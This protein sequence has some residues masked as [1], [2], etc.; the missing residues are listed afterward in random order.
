MKSIGILDPQEEIW[1]NQSGESY[2]FSEVQNF[3]DTIAPYN[4]ICD[5]SQ[6]FSGTL[7]RFPLRTKNSKLSNNCHTIS[8]L[9]KLF[10]AFIK[11]AHCL[12]LFLKSVV[13]VQ[14]IELPEISNVQFHVTVL[15]NDV[16]EYQT[17]ITGVSRMLDSQ[18]M[19][20]QPLVKKI[21]R[22][23]CVKVKTLDC[24]FESKWLVVEQV[25]SDNCEVLKVANQLHLLPWVGVAYEVG[26][27]ELRLGGRVFCCLPMPDEISSPL[28]VHVNGTFGLSDDRR[29]LK[30]KTTER[31]NDAVSIWNEMIV[32]KLLPSCYAY[33]IH[34]CTKRCHLFAGD[35]YSAWPDVIEVEKDSNWGS[36]LEPFFNCLVKLNVLWTDDVLCVGSL[37]L[38]AHVAE[39]VIVPSDADISVLTAIK[40]VMFKCG[41]KLV[42]VPNNVLMGLKYS[43]C[44]LTWLSPDLVRETLKTNPQHYIDVCKQEKLIILSYCLSDRAYS[45]IVGMVLLPLLNGTFETFETLSSTRKVFLCTAD[46]PS[47]LF[48]SF[49]IVHHLLIDEAYETELYDVAKSGATQLIMLDDNQAAAI[50]HTCLPTSCDIYLPEKCLPTGWLNLF[51]KWS[52]SHNLDAF[53][54]LFVVPLS[55]PLGCI[56]RLI[57]VKDSTVMFVDDDDDDD[58][59]KL[60]ECIKKLHLSV[61]ISKDYPYLCRKNIFCFMHKLSANG[62]LTALQNI[63]R[64]VL[65]CTQLSNNDAFAI[66][67]LLARMNKIT[68]SQLE[69]VVKIP[70]LITSKPLAI[71]VQSVKQDFWRSQVIVLPDDLPF[72][73]FPSRM[74]GVSKTHNQ[75]QFLQL[76]R[77]LGYVQFPTASELIMHTLLPMIADKTASND[78]SMAVMEE[79]LTFLTDIDMYSNKISKLPFIKVDTTSVMKSPSELYNP[80]EELCKLFYNQPVFP[81]FPFNHPAYVTKL[82]RC[83]L[84]CNIPAIEILN[85]IKD[86]SKPKGIFPQHVDEI[87]MTRSCAVLTH[88]SDNARDFQQVFNSLAIASS[89]FPI[90]CAAPEGYPKCLRW[91]GSHSHSHFISYCESVVLV[92]SD[93]IPYIAGSQVYMVR[94][95]CTF[96]PAKLK[97]LSCTSMCRP[98]HVLAHFKDV[99]DN[100]KQI[101]QDTLLTIIHHTYTFLTEHYLECYDLHT[102]SHPWIWTGD[103]FVHPKVVAMKKKLRFQHSFEPYHYIIPTE[104]H[105]YDQL[106]TYFG[107]QSETTDL[108]LV[109]TIAAIKHKCELDEADALEMIICIL[110]QLTVFGQ[111]K[112][113][114]PGVIIY[115]PTQSESL[116]LVNSNEVVYSDNECLKRYIAQS[117]LDKKYNVIHNRISSLAK[118]LHVAPLSNSISKNEYTFRNISQHEPLTRR[119]NNILRDYKDGLTIIK[120]LIQNADDA[121]ATEMNICF[122]ARTH[123]IDSKMLLFPGMASSHGPALVVYNNAQFTEADFENITE[124]AGAT[125]MDEP[126]KI[127]KFGLGFCSVYHITDIP[128]FI[129]GDSFAVF[130][131]TGKHLSEAESDQP[132]GHRI[133]LAHPILNSSQQLH[134]YRGLY[135]FDYQEKYSGT[136]FRFPFRVVAS[137]ISDNIYTEAGVKILQ[138]DIFNAGSKLLIFLKNVAKITF[139]VF[140]KETKTPSTILELHKADGFKVCDGCYHCMVTKVR[141][142]KTAYDHWLVSKCDD[143][144]AYQGVQKYALASVACLLQCE[145]HEKFLLKSLEG[146][147]FCY[148][149][150]S[151]QTG[152][153]V[154]ISSNFAVIGNRRGVWTADCTVSHRGESESE[155]NIKLMQTVIPQAYVCLLNALKVLFEDGILMD[156]SFY[157]VWPLAI[158]LKQHDPWTHFIHRVYQIITSCELLYSVFATKWLS[159]QSCQFIT[160]AIL[161]LS[162]EC[163]SCAPEVDAVLK[164]LKLL[165]V[166]LPQEYQNEI[167]KSSTC[168][169]DMFTERCFIDQFYCNVNSISVSSRVAVLKKMFQVYFHS[170]YDKGRL[171]DLK[172][173][174]VSKPSVPCIPDGKLLRTCTDVI[175]PNAMF[176]RLFDLKEQRFPMEIFCIDDIIFSAIKELGMIS[177]HLPWTMLEERARQIP[178]LYK[179]DAIDAMKRVKIL[180]QCANDSIKSG[181]KPDI[182]VLSK[183]SS[184]PCFPTKQRP[185]DFPLEWHATGGLRYGKE[186]VVPSDGKSID[187][188]IIAGS[189]V[190]IVCSEPPE[191]GGCGNIPTKVLGVFGFHPKPTVPD[192]LNQFKQLIQFFSTRSVGAKCATITHICSEVYRYLEVYATS[193]DMQPKL[194][195]LRTLPCVWSGTSF[196]HPACI[197]DQWRLNGPFLYG[198]PNNLIA[199]PKLRVLLNFK[200]QFSTCD[201]IGAL[202]KISDTYGMQPID[203]NC[204]EV[205]RLAISELTKEEK[206]P[207]GDVMMP[208]DRFVMRKAKEMYY[209]DDECWPIDKNCTMINELVPN[210]LARRLRVKPVRNKKIEMYGSRFGASRFGQREKLTQRIKNILREYPFDITVL[211]ELLQNADDAKATKMFFI[212]DCRNHGDKMVPSDEWKKLQGPA[213]L[214]WNDSTFSDKDIEGIQELGLGSKRLDAE[215]IGQYGIGFNVVYH[216]TDCPSFIT[217]DILYVLDPHCKYVPQAERLS[218]GGR[219]DLTE[220]FIE[221]F[222][223]LKSPYLYTNL[224]CSQNFCSG[225]LFRFPLRHTL[226]LVKESEIAAFDSHFN[227]QHQEPVTIS[228]MKRMIKDWAPDLKKCLYFLQNITE[229]KFC[230]IEASN[231]LNTLYHYKCN[232]LDSDIE[233]RNTIHSAF[234]NFSGSNSKP[235]MV[236]Y[237]L[238]VVE[239]DVTGKVVCKEQWMIQ[240]G[241]GDMLNESQ[242]WEYT[243]IIKPRHGIAA[244]LNKST[245]CN[246]QVFCF[247]PLPIESGLS[248]H[249]N[250]QFILDASRRA[251]WT[252]TNPNQQ[253]LRTTWNEKMFKSISSSYACLIASIYTASHN[254]KG[255]C[256]IS[257]IVNHVENYYSWFPKWKSSL[258]TL[259]CWLQLANDVY[260][261]LAHLNARVL[262]KLAV[263]GAACMIRYTLRITILKLN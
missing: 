223:D 211:K 10:D 166:M 53:T 106:F 205:L 258:I 124:L 129:S 126:L 256:D 213:L 192:V 190:C 17:F 21:A 77:P 114:L 146:E 222:K 198:V 76:L 210:E 143:Y 40:K 128:S 80:S 149:P 26:R 169:V 207:D 41:V 112:V 162:S 130:D 91:Q 194:H 122:D 184:I 58:S 236:S 200:G 163:T 118:Y 100:Y 228:K 12:L 127:G 218:P 28:P 20:V 132:C 156:Y 137:E 73:F 46:Y 116:E 201:I 238:E 90:Q 111:K 109:E 186:M 67:G 93:V 242:I 188:G 233:R 56:S 63:D 123:N 78:E 47:L 11:E 244:P 197:A 15:D 96:S 117:K 240:E 103:Q 252:S 92:K 4:K 172:L 134:P 231:S 36:I 121:G 237:P 14:I 81:L 131:P 159:I 39:V 125:K 181:I 33:L 31:Q 171:L 225:S 86:I 260:R 119:L 239:L 139:S 261:K 49:N 68:N 158:N 217:N 32:N 95:E 34:Q 170:K 199:T 18:K 151:C 232:L 247:L 42:Q 2:A 60:L 35:V 50:L 259:R 262:C 189:Q 8:S 144:I 133:N 255:S 6:S 82:M 65:N 101:R 208:S 220:E 249:I 30:W 241:V 180:L 99:I 251:L 59:G 155:W 70:I 142:T 23:C 182:V 5:F 177:G 105:K 72:A 113:D 55:H 216:L 157:T 141:D 168:T 191:L 110:N 174:L 214:V 98:K 69:V 183:L 179:R 85:I 175:D 64:T 29:T 204:H 19:L 107:V 234:C 45:K 229:I 104:L 102:F 37:G 88:I 54:G 250:G 145:P 164:Q 227:D 193:N 230:S 61:T 178:E 43:K 153:P 202:C 44:K 160:P 71:S 203:K 243:G 94:S 245:P 24:A 254:V 66:Q 150:I 161:C 206:F 75:I 185:L 57:R 257:S 176:A 187:F 97:E 84:K 108:Q 173:Y 115:V 147:L 215:S 1:E 25:G 9:R 16:K 195:E 196:I 7:F 246:G 3:K 120:E 209:R 87:A 89:W 48:K 248:V 253:D 27:K 226:Q 219:Y 154:H 224:N 51:W 221:Y 263:T 83:G 140:S 79:V 148:L 235:C 167:V 38:W 152:L 212:L 135:G 52:V 138:S 74:F 136:I 165:V 22:E 13:S 62:L